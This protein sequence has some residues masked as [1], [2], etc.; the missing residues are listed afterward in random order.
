MVGNFTRRQKL[1]RAGKS[2]TLKGNQHILRHHVKSKQKQLYARFL[3]VFYY[4]PDFRSIVQITL[5][6]ADFLVVLLQAETKNRNQ[7]FARFDSTESFQKLMRMRIYFIQLYLFKPFAL[8]N[9]QSMF[10]KI[11]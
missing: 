6:A 11:V 10:P 7:N 2:V 8:I 9:I 5:S 4:S 1:C 3:T